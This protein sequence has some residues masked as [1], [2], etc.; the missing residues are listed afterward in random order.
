MCKQHRTLEEEANL[1]I[2]IANLDERFDELLDELHIL[3]EATNFIT[4]AVAETDNFQLYSILKVQAC[5]LD[6][7]RSHVRKLVEEGMSFMRQL[8]ELPSWGSGEASKND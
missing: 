7:T 6:E 8:A 2:C 3:Y 1:R 4:E 5:Q